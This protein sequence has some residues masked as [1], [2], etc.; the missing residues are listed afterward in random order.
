MC[1]IAGIIDYSGRKTK[2]LSTEKMLRTIA[3]R[4]PNE[5]G[6]YS[7]PHASLGS[8]R[9]SIIDISG[10]QQPMSD[11]SGR[12]WIVLNGEIFNYI[13]LRRDLKGKGH[14]FKTDSDT[15]VL[16]QLYAEYG[17]DCLRM[18]N[19]QFAIAIWDKQKEELFMARDRVGIRP[20]F[21]NF[22]DGVL[23]F[24]SEIKSLFALDYIKRDFNLKS[25]EQVYTFWTVLTP[26]TSFKDIFELSPGHYM[27]FNRSGIK[28]EPFWK[29]S[30]GNDQI[31]ISVN[32]AIEKFDELFTN[33]VR[34]RLRADVEVAAYLSGGIDSSATVAYVKDIEPGV[35][36]TFSVGFEEQEFDESDYQ[37][38]A[39]KYFNTNHKSYICKSQDIAEAFPKVVWHCETPITR[40]GPVPMFMLSSLVRDNGI[41]VVITGEGSDEMFAGYNIFKETKIRNFWSKQPDS[42]IRPSLLQNL[43]PYLPQMKQANPNMLKMFYGYRLEDIDN[44]LYSHLLRWNNSNH[45]K[46]HLLPD[47]KN[48]LKDYS[49]FDELLEKLPDDFGKWDTLAKSQW[50]ETTIF[51]SGYLLSSQGDRMAM[52]NSVEGRYPFLDYRIIEFAS[53]LPPRYKL[54]CLNEKFLLKKLLNNKIPSS[55]LK[56]TK[57]AYRSPIKS[58]FLS[59]KTPESIK[60][61]LTKTACD[62]AGIFDYDS[63]KRLFSKIDKMGFATEV[64]N[65]VLA[66][67]VSTNLI[68]EQF[69]ANN[70]ENYTESRLPVIK[71]IEDY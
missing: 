62:K 26:N 2:R 5:S 11:E 32:D 4:G 61:A 67:V 22:S 57:Q 46:K 12:Y 63:L 18:L 28:I 52:A 70:P 29:L 42:L 3:Y 8:V 24:G 30:F 68:H 44:P 13:E 45:I 19:G 50:L 39:V 38:E 69:I 41:K 58:V 36:N 60:E 34:L 49:P 16:V 33:A 54:N 51:M 37:N 43:Y 10:G 47:V 66:S 56:R 25:L 71:H 64:E 27:L 31:N 35:L 20:L 7:S 9:L 6:I 65:M 40:T 1:G 17:K 59:D 48:S 15:E 14:K 53:T 21:Y 55:I 23:A